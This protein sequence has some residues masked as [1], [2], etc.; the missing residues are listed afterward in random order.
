MPELLGRMLT[1]ERRINRAGG[2]I[3][4]IK[5]SKGAVVS[6]RGNCGVRMCTS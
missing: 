4:N 1:I 5:N 6:W 2:N 3:F